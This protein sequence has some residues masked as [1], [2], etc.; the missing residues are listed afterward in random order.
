MNKNSLEEVERILADPE[1]ME[2][3]Y[4][5]VNRSANYGLKNP[6]KSISIYIIPSLEKLE[7]YEADRGA[8][9]LVRFHPL[10]AEKVFGDLEDIFGYRNLEIDILFAPGPIEFGVVT[11]LEAFEDDTPDIE[12]KAIEENLTELF[13]LVGYSKIPG[14][15]H[16]REV[17]SK[18][19]GDLSQLLTKSF[20]KS[21]ES[22]IFSLLDEKTTEA[23]RLS[24]RKSLVLRSQLFSPL[25]IEEGLVIDL[26]HSRWHILFFFERGQFAG[27]ATL[28]AFQ[29]S[30]EIYKL[31]ISQVV[32]LPPFQGKGLCS[33]LLDQVY[34]HY[35]QD[36][37]CAV[38]SV[39]SPTLYF[40][41]QR[42]R[43]L[44]RRCQSEEFD[45]IRQLLSSSKASFSETK[46]EVSASLARALKLSR[47]VSNRFSAI[48]CF[49]YASIGEKRSQFEKSY[50]ED[51]KAQ[52]D[53]QA[54]QKKN[55]FR[56]KFVSFEGQ[57]I[58]R[59]QIKQ[60]LEEFNEEPVDIDSVLKD[61]LERMA[62][63]CEKVK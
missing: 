53:K 55:A 37:K 58:L 22:E 19:G 25:F 41:N 38:I 13:K 35:L 24:D 44:L 61:E 43:S 32:I 23:D 28:F 36:A 47:E 17:L 2:R 5:R 31:R 1:E 6:L 56:R 14:K 50:R 46:S 20:A 48:F 11:K 29:T 60:I 12:P 62:V 39:E 51:L 26:K 45:P 9:E 18:E 30:L 27:F 4:K 10:F 3:M 34:S 33:L 16:L 52:Q 49:F 21:G 54:K 8:A 15:Q 40:Q 59:S 57:P 7:L 63:L 42:F